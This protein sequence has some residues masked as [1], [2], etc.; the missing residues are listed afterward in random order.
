[1]PVPVSAPSENASPSESGLAGSVAPAARWISAPSDTP[2]ASVSGLFTRERFWYSSK[3]V[4]PSPSQSLPCGLGTLGSR[5]PGKSDSYQFGKPSPSS[6][7]QD[8][9]SGAKSQS[10]R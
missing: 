9:P 1:M 6:S 3:S 10:S 8:T 5:Q 4:A 2:S 7:T